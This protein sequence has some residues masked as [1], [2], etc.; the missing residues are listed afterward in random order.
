MKRFGGIFSMETTNNKKSPMRD[1]M[2]RMRAY[3][4]M[5]YDIRDMLQEYYRIVTIR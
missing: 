5:R 4:C 1:A 3:M 2:S